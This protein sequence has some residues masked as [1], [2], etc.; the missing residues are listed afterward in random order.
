MRCRQRHCFVGFIF[1]R[2]RA[3]QVF[4]LNTQLQCCALE[5]GKNTT[6]LTPEANSMVLRQAIFELGGS[7]SEPISARKIGHL[8]FA[9]ILDAA[10]FNLDRATLRSMPKNEKYR[11]DAPLFLIF[12]PKIFALLYQK[13]KASQDSS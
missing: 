2:K 8:F 13:I 9:L 5:L 1:E 3:R 11:L 6:L 7:S 10:R 12:R 4:R